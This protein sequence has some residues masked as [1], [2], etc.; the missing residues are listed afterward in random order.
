MEFLPLL[1]QRVFLISSWKDSLLLWA[2]AA[3][4]NHSSLCTKG[5]F[6]G[7]WVTGPQGDSP[8]P[9]E[10]HHTPTTK[11]SWV[12][13]QIQWLD[14]TWGW[15]LRGGSEYIL[16]GNRAVP[17][18]PDVQR[19]LPVHKCWCFT[20]GVGGIWCLVKGHRYQPHLLQGEAMWSILHRGGDMYHSL[21]KKCLRNPLLPLLPQR[22]EL[23]NLRQ[24]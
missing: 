13:S 19:W 17:E 18:G 4:Y 5:V 24:W 11:G 12:W 20:F 8:V 23:W 7:L 10:E 14:G 22:S 2:M 9:D 1:R 16:Y 6:T 21:F 15:H 3:K